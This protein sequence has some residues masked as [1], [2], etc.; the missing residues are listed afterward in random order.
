MRIEVLRCY[1]KLLTCKGIGV[2]QARFLLDCFNDVLKIFDEEQWLNNRDKKLSVDL[3]N[4]LFDKSNDTIINQEIEFILKEKIQC[5]GLLD[6]DY[7]KLLKECPD[8][9]VILFYKGNLEVLTT[10]CLAVVGTRKITSY[11]K[12]CVQNLCNELQGYPITIVS[13]M[14]YGVDIEAFHQCKQVNLPMVGVMGTSFKRIYP[15][16]HKKYYNYLVEKGLIITEYAGFNELVPELFTRRNRIIAGLSQATVVIESA[17]KGGALATAY[18]ANEYNREV[19]AVPGRLND[20][21]SQG[22][23]RLIQE[24]R[25]QVLFDFST[26]ITDLNLDTKQ[27]TIN[28]STPKVDRNSLNDYQRTIVDHL[29]NGSLHIDTLC[30]LTGYEMNIL[31]SELMLL[32]L[33]D[34]VVGLPGKLFQLK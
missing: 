31:N 10:N 33:Q 34:L 4:K 26:L 24:S 12:H 32:E 11:G 21:Y 30:E 16:A 2:L 27:E 20:I 23:L 13:G 18:Y 14:A 29:E 3:K 7:P 1:L 8:A 19:Y 6:S 25:A 9:P 17:F 28:V 22:C 5:V 15:A